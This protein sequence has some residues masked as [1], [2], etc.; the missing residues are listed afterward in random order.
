[1]IGNGR[2]LKVTK[3]GIMRETVIQKDGSTSTVSMEVKVVPDLWVNLFSLTQAIQNGAMIGN[4][5]KILSVKK[6]DRSIFFDRVF[7]TKSGFVAGVEIG[8]LKQ[9]Q[10]HVTMV[11]GYKLRLDDLHKKLGHIG[12]SSTRK[13]AKFYG[14]N[15]TGPMLKCSDCG[16]GKAKQKSVPK[17]TQENSKSTIAGERLFI[18]ISSINSVSFGGSKFWLLILDDA[19]DFTWSFFLKKKSETSLKVI[20]L[21]KELKAKNN[22][23][24]KYIRLDN[25]GENKD[26]EK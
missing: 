26:L 10:A 4:K 13:T 21:I 11:K 12:E 25:S 16:I 3:A 1:M 20:E 17:M 24:V 6:G 5:G 22:K 19:T 15:V 14:W 9:D 23:V 7:N 18:D 2:S 8:P